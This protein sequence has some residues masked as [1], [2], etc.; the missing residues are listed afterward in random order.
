MKV[1]QAIAD[2]IVK[3]GITKVFTFMSDDTAK[4]IVELTER[5][6]SVYH[7]RN[8]HAAVGMA[9]GF[10]RA[11]AGVGV[12]VIGQGPALTMASN[13]IVT[14]AKAKSPVLIIAGQPPG[15]APGIG[16]K[17]NGLTPMVMKFIDQP[18]YATVLNVPHVEITSPDAAA[19]DVAHAYRAVA[20]SRSPLLVNIPAPVFDAEAGG[21]HSSLELSSGPPAAMS[22]D[23]LSMVA[24]L[25]EATWASQKPV[26]VAGRGAVRAGA[27]D[28]LVRLG[29][30]TGALL[31]TTIMGKGAFEGSPYA[32]GVVGT[33]AT[34]VAAELVGSA[35]L[36]LVFGSAL[37]QYTT[38]WGAIFGKAKVIQFDA[39][40]SALGRY[41]D[42]EMS[43]GADACVAAEQLATE[44]ANRGHRAIGYRT[45]EVLERIA[46][47]PRV[48]EYRDVSDDSRIDP[49][50]LMGTL[51]TVLP[52]ERVV[53]IDA[54]N[55][56]EFAIANLQVP[57]TQS[58]L[59]PIEYGSIACGLGN[60]LGAAVARPEACCVL[61]IGDAGLMSMLGDLHTAVRYGLKVLVVVSND[62][63]VGAELHFLRNQGYDET[64]TRYANPSFAAIAEAMGMPG[65]TVR[66]AADL[67][68]LTDRIRASDGPLLLDCIV[69]PEVASTSHTKR[70]GP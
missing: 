37:N 50:T 52:R 54:G 69:N 34:P 68:G 29:D 13:A 10:A 21:A 46:N 53:V 27:I 43:V 40:A 7:T 8:E 55:H 9:D 4:L 47:A 20:A 3:L 24:D 6:V 15:T 17:A 67:I 38:Y 19:A 26:I 42:V 16:P 61:C 36:V 30:L 14:A 65:A 66:T 5:G 44:L 25:I 41:L 18:S 51:D 11:S 59:W 62:S 57:D 33:F 23:D 12:A 60:V 2:E 49:R 32:V 39:D 28:G 58:F 63:A 45:P 1:C 70:Y 22:P 35:D 48:D 31:A 56:M 64:V